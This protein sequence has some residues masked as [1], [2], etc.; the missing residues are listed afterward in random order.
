[1]ENSKKDPLGFES[2]MNA[3]NTSMK[4]MMDTMPAYWS[5]FKPGQ[6]PEDQQQSKTDFDTFTAGLKSW[7]T[8][9]SA[10]AT[11]E[12]MAAL[13][14]GAETVPDMAAQFGQAIMES[15][16]ELQKRVSQTALNLGESVEAYRFEKLDENLLHVWSDIYEKEFRKF[17]HIP[18]LGLTREYQERFNDMMDKFNQ[19]QTHQSEFLRLLGLPFQR[20][21]TVMQEKITKMAEIGELPEDANVY[22]QMWIKILEGHFMTLFQT[23]EYVQ[24]LSKTL[25]ALSTFSKAKDAVFEDLIKGLP[26]AQRSEMDDLAREVYELKKRIRTLEKKLK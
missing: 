6:S 2:M 24:A 4:N 16:V 22:Y 10:M 26:I 3:W 7:Q 8:L 9:A 18:Q 14:K 19:F 1:M 21:M 5:F 20:S 23:P 12:S 13:L 15:M 11:P 25:T 17:F